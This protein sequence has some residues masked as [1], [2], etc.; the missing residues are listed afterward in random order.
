MG[1]HYPMPGGKSDKQRQCQYC[2]V[3]FDIRGIG[4]HE[5]ACKARRDR[6]D[7][8]MRY[9][10]ALLKQKS[11]Q[12]QREKGRYQGLLYKTKIINN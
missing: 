7:R 1:L 8:D 4:S 5:K 9:A 3:L 11:K 12:T 10:R 6:E 2:H